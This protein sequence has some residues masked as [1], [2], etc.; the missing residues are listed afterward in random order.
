MLKLQFRDRR[1]EAVWLVDRTF[2]IGK[3]PTNSLMIEE[4]EIKD[5]HAEISNDKDQLTLINRSTDQTLWVNGKQLSGHGR[6]YAG[7]IITIGSIELELVDPK[8]ASKQPEAASQKE[9]SGSWAIRSS[10]SW[11]EKNRFSIEGKVIMG[12]DQSCDITLPLDH[13]SRHHVELEVRGGQ[14]F[15][16]DLDSSNGT[17]LNG[18]QIS[19]SPLKPGDKIKLDVVTFE[20]EGPDHDPN[21]TIIRTIKPEQTKAQKTPD[22]PSSQPSKKTAD[23]P[24][25]GPK[26]SSGQ[27]PNKN[28]TN[29]RLA[30]EGKQQWISGDSNPEIPKKSK[31]GLLLLAFSGVLAITSALVFISVYM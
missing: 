11:L 2:T 10:A 8:L 26:S 13:L 23:K 14:L 18:K 17:F 7:D 22:E 9:K 15:I 25:P 1:R 28:I 20:V 6:I 16:K 30:A 19:E 4:S 29:K 3:N 31:T 5:F 24:A 21:K 27:T 12:R